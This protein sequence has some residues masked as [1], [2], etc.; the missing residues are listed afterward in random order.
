MSDLLCWTL[1][2]PKWVDLRAGLI[3]LTDKQKT[4]VGL[5][6]LSKTNDV[7]SI[8][9][10]SAWAARQGALRFFFLFCFYCRWHSLW[11]SSLCE[12][13]WIKISVH[14]WQK[15]ALT[16]WVCDYVWGSVCQQ[17][18][19]IWKASLLTTA[20]NDVCTHHSLPWNGLGRHRRGVERVQKWTLVLIENP[21]CRKT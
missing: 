1:P 4:T 6:L 9:M 21:V 8:H 12:P 3:L 13:P 5:A 7:R 2:N 17:S 19:R 14:M 11:W 20:V 16:L 10:D 15:M 18:V